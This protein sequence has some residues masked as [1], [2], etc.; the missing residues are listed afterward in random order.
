MALV[1]LV[2]D[3]PNQRL[4]YQME[5]EDWGHQVI[6]PERVEDALD[7]LQTIRP[8]IVV[9]DSHLSDYREMDILPTIKDLAPNLPVIIYTGESLFEEDYRYFLADACL[10]KSSNIS[11]LL[12][13]VDKLLSPTNTKEKALEFWGF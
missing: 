9:L 7:T 5:L 2:E 11:P 13:T 3:H 6:A 12:S 8:D 10:I 4:L 1:L